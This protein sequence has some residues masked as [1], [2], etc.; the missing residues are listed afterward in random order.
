MS[1]RSCWDVCGGSKLGS[2]ALSC[3]SLCWLLKGCCLLQAGELAE[4]KEQLAVMTWEKTQLQADLEQ[5]RQVLED[6][7]HRASSAAK[8]HEAEVSDMPCSAV[9]VSIV[10]S[11]M[12]ESVM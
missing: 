12:E 6:E 8:G 1:S 10:T 7:Q 11:E 5:A 9:V 4:L 3:S 2:S